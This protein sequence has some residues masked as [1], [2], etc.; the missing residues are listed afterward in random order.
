MLSV[1]DEVFGCPSDGQLYKIRGCE[2]RCP[3]VGAEMH[4]GVGTEVHLQPP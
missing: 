3:I 2:R 1:K 4:A